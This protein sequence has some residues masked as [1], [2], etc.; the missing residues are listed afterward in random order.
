MSGTMITRNTVFS[1]GSE[2][3]PSSDDDEETDLDYLNSDLV[4]NLEN[5]SF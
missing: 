3:E 5:C 2:N 4:N 1:V